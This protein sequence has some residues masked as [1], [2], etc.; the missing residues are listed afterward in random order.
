M[1]T[2]TKPSDRSSSVATSAHSYASTPS[3]VTYRTSITGLSFRA[4]P[5]EPRWLVEVSSRSANAGRRGVLRSDAAPDRVD[6]RGRT[7]IAG[8]ADVHLV[9][10]VAEADLG[11]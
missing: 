2:H 11:F 4:A 1:S 6:Q 10:H 5:A 8:E 7:G 9:H 3:A